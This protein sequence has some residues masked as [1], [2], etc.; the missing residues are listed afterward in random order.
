MEITKEAAKLILACMLEDDLDPTEWAFVVDVDHA[1]Q[2]MFISFTKDQY[3]WK[4]FFGLNVVMSD[5]M[6]G[7]TIDKG[8]NADGLVGIIFRN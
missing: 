7:T 2:Q 4:N 3:N 1:K 8:K 6:L 5:H